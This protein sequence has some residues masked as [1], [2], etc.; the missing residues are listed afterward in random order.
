MLAD[1]LI[2]TANLLRCGHEGAANE[3]LAEVYELLLALPAQLSSQQL[4][5][6]KQLFPVMYD[7]Q[8]RRDWIFLADILQYEV[9]KVVKQN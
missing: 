4:E 7:A 5:W 6:L 3:S 1:K 2:R 8:K 9:I